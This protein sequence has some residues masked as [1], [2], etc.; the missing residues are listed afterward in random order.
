MSGRYTP[1][2]A[3]V[4]PSDPIDAALEVL[5][6]QGYEVTTVAEIADAA[7]I[8]RSTF[9][10]RFGSKEDVVFHDH[11]VLIER[12][13][14][15][16]ATTSAD[17]VD[18]VLAAAR[19]VFDH[20]VARRRIS[21]LRQ[22][23]VRSVAALRDREIITSNRYQR[24]LTAYLRRALPDTPARGFGSLA[25]ASAVVAVH[26]S[27]LQHWLAD[28]DTDRSAELHRQ[29]RELAAW[30]RPGLEGTSPPAR[31][32]VVAVAAGAG[33]ADI[34]RAIRDAGLA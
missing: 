29:L 12:V 31:V 24:L 9:F 21:L 5:A 1:S 16:L 13:E 25:F 20:H 30:Y 8:S 26:G 7:R 10:R 11:D 18:A 22:D 23:L 17:P 15:H 2:P 3:D 32:A 4:E 19:M 27:V 33:D 34:L 28:P 6:R 14:H